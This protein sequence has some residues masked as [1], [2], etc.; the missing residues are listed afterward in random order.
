M[1]LTTSLALVLATLMGASPLKGAKKKIIP[2]KVDSTSLAVAPKTEPDSLFG[3]VNVGPSQSASWI[4]FRHLGAWSPEIASQIQIDNPQIKNLDLLEVGDVLRLRRSLNQ[5]LLT[6]RQQISKAIRKAVITYV[7]GNAS[8]QHAGA[9]SASL[10]ANEFLSPGD[11]ITTSAGA[12][13]ELIIDNQSVLRLRDRTTLSLVAIQDSSSDQRTRTS[14]FLEAGRVWTKVR[15]WAGPLVGFQVKMPNAIA[16]VHGTTFE[17]S[18]DSGAQGTVTVHEGI[19]G[20]SSLLQ[21][22]ETPV[23]AGK[24]VFIKKD[25]QIS[26]PV[27]TTESSPDWNR[28]NEMQDKSLE[29]QTSAQQNDVRL[30]QEPLGGSLSSLVPDCEPTCQRNQAPRP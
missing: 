15:K 20:V 21:P 2:A 25:G 7:K 11:R 6:P 28:F 14:V 17:C 27:S 5:R 22:V 13:V 12:V 3:V 1:V 29:E 4:A 19:V 24:S 23:A 10:R 18:V 30:N 9:P 26:T 8:V 16:G